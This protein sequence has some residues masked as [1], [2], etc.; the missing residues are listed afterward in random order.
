MS[1][2]LPASQNDLHM[3]S[4]KLKN[5]HDKLEEKINGS[6]SVTKQINARCHKMCGSMGNSFCAIVITVTG[7]LILYSLLET[8]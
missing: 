3:V 2:Q 8:I 1:R 5:N 6:W 7:G 4:I